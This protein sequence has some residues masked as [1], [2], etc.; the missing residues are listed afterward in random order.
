VANL[1]QTILIRTDLNFPT[2]L[3]AAQCAHLH[4]ERFR[5]AIREA[6]KVPKGRPE[7]TK[8][9]SEWLKD[10]YLFI[11]GVPNAEVLDFF[12]KEAD[13]ALIPIAEWRDTVYINI[14]DTQR[15]A[16][17]PVKVGAALGPVDSDSIKTI[18]GDLPLL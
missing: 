18:I 16:F 3:L 11:H 10:P 15:K 14:S 7:F 17:F 2:G 13:K 5:V 8:D 12:I 1:R 9:D 4:M 6:S